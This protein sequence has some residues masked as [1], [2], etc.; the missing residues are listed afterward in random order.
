MNVFPSGFVY[1]WIAMDSGFCTAM[2]EW[3]GDL[4]GI[5]ETRATDGEYK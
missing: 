4:D 3:I 5:E 2:K 1:G